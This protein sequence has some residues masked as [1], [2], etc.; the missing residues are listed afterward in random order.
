[1]RRCSL[2][3]K[4]LT[5][6]LSCRLVEIGDSK[7]ILFGLFRE[8]NCDFSAPVSSAYVTLL[9]PLFISS[10]IQAFSPK[11]TRGPREDFTSRSL[12]P[13]VFLSFA[14]G[15]VSPLLL[16]V[17]LLCL[18]KSHSLHGDGIIHFAFRFASARKAEVLFA[19]RRFPLAPPSK[20][21][22]FLLI[23]FF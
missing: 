6:Q 7:S 18:R 20:K 19:S 14:P 22:N 5:P 13:T 23:L 4:E 10:N 3:F 8:R 9:L 17:S 15:S 12:L 21:A 1:M 2:S 16:G 11:R